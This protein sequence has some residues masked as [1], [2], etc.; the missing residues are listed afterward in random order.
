LVTVVVE[1]FTTAG[2]SLSMSGASEACTGTAASGPGAVAAASRN[3][4][5]AG[6]AAGAADAVAALP[7]RVHAKIAA[8]AR[9]TVTIRV[10]RRMAPLLGLVM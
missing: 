2:R 1:M 8:A 10:M 6:D 7:S 4:C 5:G 9:E 3:S